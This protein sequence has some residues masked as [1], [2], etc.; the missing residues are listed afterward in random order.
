MAQYKVPQDVEADD[1][2]LG[3]FSFRQFVY[4]MIA[5][6]LIAACVPLFKLFP[7]LIL[8][9]IPVILFLL[10]LALPLKK[11]QPMETYLSAVV[12]FHLKPN[13]RI[14]EPGEPEN[15]IVITAPKKTD[16]VHLK[17]I[18]QEEASHRL[19]FL[20]DIVDTEGY[21]IKNDIASGVRAEVYAEANSV[22]DIFEVQNPTFNQALQQ[23]TTN[24]HNEIVD[25]MRNAIAKNS[26]NH[27]N[28]IIGHNNNSQ[29]VP[30]AYPQLQFQPTPQ[31]PVNP[32]TDYSTELPTDLPTDLPTMTTYEQPN[33]ATQPVA[34]FDPMTQYQQPDPFPT[35]PQV[36][37]LPTP[38]YAE[39][40]AEQAQQPI[41]PLQ[42][43][44]P[45]E[46]DYQQAPIT[47]NP[48]IINLAN[49]SDYSI[50]TIAQEAN[51]INNKP[52]SEVF[53]SLH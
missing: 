10:V 19:S 34:S 50:E 8:I 40:P 16:E 45:F 52:D 48:E 36:P 44:N 14:W 20:A 31:P 33:I 18:S 11:D 39:M 32:V 46:D 5:G 26:E 15:T 17:N 27:A 1:K 37:D 35:A 2:L 43:A 28:T 49:N 13:K 30:E 22:T 24:Y 6:A 53:V 38:Q 7:L 23:T 41:Q 47:Q 51:R 29:P 42:P 21:A 9:P 4:L 12:S 25:Q 3:P